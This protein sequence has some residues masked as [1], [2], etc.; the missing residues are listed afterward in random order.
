MTRRVA[1]CT[2]RAMQRLPPSPWAFDDRR[3]TP[4][5][6]ALD[7]LS[8]Y[9]WIETRIPGGPSSRLGQFI[10]VAY[11]IEYGEDSQRQTAL[12]LLGLL[13]FPSKGQWW[14]YGASDER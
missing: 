12:N 9:D 10:D 7:E 6:I 4:G 11:V 5:G 13:G 14:V 8:L 3:W 1:Q 2:A